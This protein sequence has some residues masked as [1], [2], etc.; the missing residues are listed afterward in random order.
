MK[1][2]QYSAAPPTHAV[3]HAAEGFL[4]LRG[5][6]GGTSKDLLAQFRAGELG[7]LEFD[8]ITFRQTD[9]PNRN[10]VRFK[11]GALAKLARSFVGAPFM[12]DHSRSLADRGGTVIASELTEHKGAPAFTQTVRLTAPWAVEQALLGNLDRFSI[13]WSATGDVLC[14]LCEEPW[15]PGFFGMLPTCN[16]FPGDLVGEGDDAEVVEVLYTAAEGTELSGV[17]VPAVAGTEIEAIRAALSAQRSGRAPQE[18]RM[19]T[20]PKLASVLSMADDATEGELVARVKEL[21]A[22]YSV[23]K[24]AH[25]ALRAADAKRTES[26]VEALI[27]EAHNDGVWEETR[28][29]KGAVIDGPE[30]EVVRLKAAGPGGIDDARKWVARLRERGQRV[31]IRRP[32][33]SGGDD[34]VP[35]TGLLTD[36][37]KKMARQMGVTDE[38]FIAERDRIAAARAARS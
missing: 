31:P 26:D 12:R 34:P 29:A 15:R 37:Q 23:E 5:G 10:F 30:D 3:H 32:A 21:L 8:A 13:A 16:H 35:P 1:P 28:D 36:Q 19:P 4:A 33:K 7:E 9:E 14:G 25:E 22:E 17:V 38:Q 24:K 20:F 6:K 11:K 27:K 18:N 2:G